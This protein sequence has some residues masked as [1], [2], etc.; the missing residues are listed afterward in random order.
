MTPEEF[1]EH[2][3]QHSITQAHDIV[4]IFKQHDAKFHTFICEVSTYLSSRR[5]SLT[6]DTYASQLGIELDKIKRAYVQNPNL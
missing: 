5:R 4:N 1:V 2:L 3:R 6:Y